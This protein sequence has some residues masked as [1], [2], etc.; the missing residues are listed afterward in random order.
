M[1]EQVSIQ[2][3]IPL[4]GKR[5]LL[6]VAE[7]AIEASNGRLRI[8]LHEEDQSDDFVPD[9]QRFL[10]FDE[11]RLGRDIELYGFMGD[12]AM[13]WQ[14]LLPTFLE[15]VLLPIKSKLPDSYSRAATKLRELGEEVYP[16][17][18]QQ[19]WAELL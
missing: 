10:K 16:P 13:G 8:A 9:A 6:G 2:E 15:E 4:E 18:I 19:R 12:S 3:A 17:D 1:A 7:A 14:Q 11:K 5:L